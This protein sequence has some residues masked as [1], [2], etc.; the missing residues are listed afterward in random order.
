MVNSSSGIVSYLLSYFVYQYQLCILSS[1]GGVMKKFIVFLG[2]LFILSGCDSIKTTRDLCLTSRNVELIQQRMEDS[3]ESGLE[4]EIKDGLEKRDVPF[5]KCLLD[6]NYDEVKQRAEDR[7]RSSSCSYSSFGCSEK[8]H[9]D[10]ILTRAINSG[11]NIKDIT[12]LLESVKEI[13]AVNSDE[14]SPLMLACSR[15]DM[16]LVQ[17]L[18]SKGASI[19]FL[20]KNGD[21]PLSA[22]VSSGNLALVKFI[23]ES[24]AGKNLGNSPLSEALRLSDK[25]KADE[26][27]DYLLKIGVKYGSDDLV[28][29]SAYG[30]SKVVDKLL[31]LGVSPTSDWDTRTPLMAA[32]AGGHPDI[33][34]R[35][36]KTKAGRRYYK[37]RRCNLGGEDFI[38]GL[39]QTKI[40]G[41]DGFQRD[42]T[43]LSNYSN[44][45][46]VAAN[47]LLFAVRS[48][49]AESVKLLL[50]AG[51]N[52]NYN[53]SFICRQ[54]REI[55]QRQS[56]VNSN[57]SGCF[58]TPLI[59][60]SEQ[61]NLE[62]IKL[63]L[64][65]GAKINY[66]CTE[67]PPLWHQMKGDK[68]IVRTAFSV[69]KDEETRNLLAQMGATR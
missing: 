50:E 54:D 65:H 58:V 62:I 9:I 69:A 30:M 27:A 24:G 15:G 17:L 48:G 56:D 21:T 29:A 33:I 63:L 23:I 18:I 32:S 53:T 67:L 61:G 4:A 2:A 66:Q 52:P 51:A 14:K 28:T 40:E 8:R 49:N 20:S 16:D 55:Y 44:S 6:Y 43:G 57:R 19:N 13:N 60:A 45:W 3:Y 31:S 64:K 37:W 5:L 39:D 35:L 10:T 47:A 26:I 34:R 36:L 12:P 25:T 38:M 68:P 46:L 1:Y 11:W 59:L 7:R 42:F 41:Y 22:A